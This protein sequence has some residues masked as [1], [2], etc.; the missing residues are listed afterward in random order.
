MPLFGTG[1]TCFS[2][3]LSHLLHLSRPI[4]TN[5]YSSVGTK[6]LVDKCTWIE[7]FIH[8]PFFQFIPFNPYSYILVYGNW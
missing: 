8:S 1:W 2:V 5:Q 6:I 4:R 3:Q 7:V